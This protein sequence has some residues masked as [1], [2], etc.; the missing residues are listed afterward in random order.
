MIIPVWCSISH[1]SSQAYVLMAMSS[2]DHTRPD[3]AGWRV[4][5]DVGGTFTDLVLRRS[6]GAISVFKVLSVPEDPAKGVLSAFQSAASAL[7]VTLDAFLASC[8]ICVHGST[9]ATNTLLERK[10]ATVG[11]IATEGFRQP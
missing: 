9:V 10:G 6:D 3:G 4:G 11:L 8:S 5:V 1:G 2:P 7:D